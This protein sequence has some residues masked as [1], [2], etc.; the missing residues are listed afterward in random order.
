MFLTEFLQLLQQVVFLPVPHTQ[1]HPGEKK[2]KSFLCVKPAAFQ[3]HKV[4][5][6][7][8]SKG[9]LGVRTLVSAAGATGASVRAGQGCPVPV[10]A[11]SAAVPAQGTAE[12]VSDAG[13]ASGKAC[14]RKGQNTARVFCLHFDP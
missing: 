14:V 12:P 11:G 3:K 8:S 7:R 10:P 13:G 9:A 4:P 5:E 1:L 2:K 6:V